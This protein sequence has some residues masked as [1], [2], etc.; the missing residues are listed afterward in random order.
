[1]FP[2]R[3]IYPLSLINSHFDVGV[4]AGSKSLRSATRIDFSRYGVYE[5]CTRINVVEKARGGGIGRERE[6]KSVGG[7]KSW[8]RER[9]GKSGAK[10]NVVLYFFGGNARK[11]TFSS[12]LFSFASREFLYLIEE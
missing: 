1:M 7:K 12:N 10:K 4:G 6:P 3:S 9:K 8:R 2:F 11:L 5:Q